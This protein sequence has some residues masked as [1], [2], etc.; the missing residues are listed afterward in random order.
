MNKA[1]SIKILFLIF[2]SLYITSCDNSKNNKEND[3][4]DSITVLEDTI[5]ERNKVIIGTFLGNEKRNYYGNV[6]PDS[7]NIIWKL[8]L[9][10]G[11]TKVSGKTL[12]W[13]GAGWT[14]QPLIVEED[15][16]TY[17]IQG[18]Y[19]HNLMKIKADSGNIVWK[20]NFGDA[21][22]GTGTIWYNKNADSLNRL[23][24]LQGSRQGYNNSFRQAVIP[25][26]RAISYFTGKELWRLNSKL[27]KSYS[28]DVDA[29]AL[30][31]KDTAYIGL[32]NGIFTVF[33][34]DPKKA[35]TV[36]GIFQPVIYE[37]HQIYEESDRKKH[38]GNLVTESSPSLL[39]NRIYVSSGSGHVYGYNLKKREIDW[40]FFT[41]SDMDGSPAVT[42]DNCIIVP[43]EREYIPGCGGVFKLDPSLPADSSVQ[44]FFP[45]KN[46]H[47]AFWEGGII[48][49]AS[50]NDSYRKN[51]DSV[52]NLAAFSAIDGYI[53]IVNTKKTTGEKA[54]GPNKLNYYDVPELVFKYNTGQSIS[55][56]IFVG[57]KLI[58][59]GY[60]GIYLF[61]F[62][63][64]LNFRLIQHLD[65]GS[66]ESTPVVHNGRLYIATKL[67]Y[68]YCLGKIEDE[69]SKFI[70]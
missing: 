54:L 26:Y 8:N 52:P 31:L 50:I 40:D 64:S 2:F 39:G 46:L 24:I 58:A 69:K 10:S 61:E 16:V 63:N 45:V 20:Y 27:T 22:K 23:V 29:S 48:G 55:T 38:R 30:I 18:T 6:A 37:E 11:K 9:G 51:G 35:D 49:S 21:I 36:D 34:P 19:S 33:N 15:S 44:W 65:I 59:A 17:L 13:S 42:D 12:I 43:I 60:S 1:K 7:L 66:T 4:T 53:Y 5:L 28:R 32:E 14:G 62:D 41:G 68:L 67:G 25:S 56:P 70:L 57:N 3:R 47:F